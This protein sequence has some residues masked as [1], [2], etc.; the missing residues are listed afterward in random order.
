MTD[1]AL[2]PEAMRLESELRSGL[3]PGEQLLWL[4]MPDPGRMKA[5]FAMWL[6]AVPWTAFAFAWTGLALTAYLSSFGVDNTAGAPFWGWVFPLFGTPFIAVGIWMLRMPFVAQT[7]AKHTLYALTNRRLMM[8]THRKAKTIKS[9]DLN[10][11]GPVMMKETADGW[12]A[13]SVETGS[14]IDSDGDRRTD[15]FEIP[16]VPNVA[17]LYRLLL[18]QK[19]GVAHS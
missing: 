14:T 2:S 15:R 7:D 18:E 3:A 19:Q 16:A 12:G 9:V 11:L 1:Y 5:A 8:L 10:K 6:F 13:L 17:R 4:A